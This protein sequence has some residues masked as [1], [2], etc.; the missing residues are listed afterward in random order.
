MA[1][2]R[3]KK[4]LRGGEPRHF[5]LP[6]GS[7]LKLSKL[8]HFIL[9]NPLPGDPTNTLYGV[10]KHENERLVKEGA[11]RSK[12]LKLDTNFRPINNGTDPTTG[13]AKHK[14]WAYA[15][16]MAHHLEV[17]GLILYFGDRVKKPVK[18]VVNGQV[19]QLDGQFPVNL[20]NIDMV[21][22]KKDANG[23]EVAG[24][25][26]SIARVLKARLTEQTNA[27]ADHWLKKANYY[28]VAK[29][30]PNI[31]HA[32]KFPQLWRKRVVLTT[33]RYYKR[34]YAKN[35]SRDMD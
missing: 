31:H 15:D 13:L 29:Y 32:R 34:K 21:G 8:H 33:L 11:D 17:P 19:V 9:G 4:R 18:E 20:L 25:Y 10:R 6:P 27:P 35:F 14:L 28:M 12:W 7:S 3:Q 2:T 1:K 22:V 26:D 24:E 16:N 23:N 30:C 5:T